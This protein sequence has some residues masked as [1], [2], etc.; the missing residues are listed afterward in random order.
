MFVLIVYKAMVYLIYLIEIKKPYT[1]LSL[2]GIVSPDVSGT[3]KQ[4][5]NKSITLIFYFLFFLFKFLCYV[6][7]VL[8]KPFK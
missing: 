6:L 5:E 3:N 2:S 4:L 8:N 1:F 7:G